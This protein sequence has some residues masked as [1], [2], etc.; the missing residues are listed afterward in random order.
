MCVHPCVMFPSTAQVSEVQ[1]RKRRSANK[2]AA[3]AIVGASLEVIQKKRTEKPEVRQASRD[4]A[5]R[6]IKERAKKAKADKAKNQVRQP[7][8]MG[9]WMGHY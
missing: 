3:R 2:S 9:G 4:A 5:L 8:Y 7:G 1:R 6:E